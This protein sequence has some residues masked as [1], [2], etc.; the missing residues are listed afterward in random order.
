MQRW[1]QVNYK[2]ED[3]ATPRSRSELFRQ[4][5][6]AGLLRDP[7]P[8]FEYAEARNLTSHTYDELDAKAAYSLSV[9][10]ALDARDLLTK[11]EGSH[12]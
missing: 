12:D 5:A 10:F 3:A 11:L 2:K 4:A 1:L 8:W 7:Q 9:R 6:R